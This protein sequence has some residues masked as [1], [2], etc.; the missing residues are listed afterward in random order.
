MGP[1]ELIHNSREAASSPGSAQDKPETNENKNSTPVS[2][3]KTGT[4]AC[5]IR[6]WF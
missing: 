4:E 6:F 2:R 5:Q 3:L 1:G